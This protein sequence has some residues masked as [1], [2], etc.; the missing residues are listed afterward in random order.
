[1]VIDNPEDPFTKVSDMQ[2]NNNKNSSVFLILI[3]NGRMWQKIFHIPHSVAR[4]ISFGQ[5]RG[6]MITSQIS[7]W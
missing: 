3:D 2:Y 5:R 4:V 1:M 7:T 6:F